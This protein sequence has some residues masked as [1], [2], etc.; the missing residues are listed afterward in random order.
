MATSSNATKTV[1]FWFSIVA[2][3]YM[4]WR[5]LVM[6]PIPWLNRPLA[7][8]LCCS[9]VVLTWGLWQGVKSLKKAREGSKTA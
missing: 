3:G 7:V 9:P 6:P 1:V 2:L 4:L 8:F 5:L